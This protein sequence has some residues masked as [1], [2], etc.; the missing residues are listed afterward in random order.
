MAISNVAALVQNLVNEQYGQAQGAQATAGTP[1]VS[2]AGNGTV[3]EDTFT[4]SAQ[5]NTAQAAATA[6]ASPPANAAQQVSANS[7]VQAATAAASGTANAQ[8]QLQTLN[9]SLAALGLS[10]ADIQQIDQ[11]ASQ[12]KD[13]SPSAYTTL[14]LQYEAS[15]QQ[16]AQPST[17]HGTATANTHAGANQN[18]GASNV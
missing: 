16:T 9:A 11:I 13:F 18:S 1:S 2:K 14:A 8:N 17:A 7:A 6:P 5:N 4:A 10:N 12:T 15:A 3:P